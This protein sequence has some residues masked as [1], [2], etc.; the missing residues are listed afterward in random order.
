MR[1]R[2]WIA[3][4][5]L[6]LA[7]SMGTPPMLLLRAQDSSPGNRIVIPVRDPERPYQVRLKTNNEHVRIEGYAGKEIV[8]EF[9]DRNGKERPARKSNGLTRLELNRAAG[10][11]AQQDENVIELRLNE[12][13]SSHVVLRIPAQYSLYLRSTNSDLVVENAAGEIDVDSV[14]GRVNLLNTRGAI[15]AH[16]MNGNLVVTVDRVPQDRPMSLS[17]FNGNLDITFPA[18]VRATLKLKADNGDAYSEFPIQLQQPPLPP[19]PPTPPNPP[20]T[21]EPK[22]AQRMERASTATV[23]GGGPEIQLTSFNG[24]IMI[25]KRH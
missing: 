7:S 3:A 18:D 1:R 11:S 19:T 16:A 9:V 13:V 2:D 14:N 25:R 5:V 10:V 4:P 8:A 17:T 23:N 15:T 20:G 22:R 24:K 6:M 21:P 12:N